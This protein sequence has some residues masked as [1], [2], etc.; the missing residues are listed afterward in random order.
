MPTLT[1]FLLARIGEVEA[2]VAAFDEEW[3]TTTVA[4]P[5]PIGLAYI[6]DTEYMQLLVEP[7]HVLAE[8]EAKRQ[9]IERHLYLQGTLAL[10]ALPYA[11][12]PDYREDWRP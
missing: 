2:E 8:C 1:E 11:D 6:T 4:G 3:G 7:A 12:H 10:L 9:I 5:V